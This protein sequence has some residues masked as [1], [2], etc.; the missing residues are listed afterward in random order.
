MKQTKPAQAMELRS[1]SP[2]FAGRPGAHQGRFGLRQRLAITLALFATAGCGPR[3]MD[4]LADVPAGATREQVVSILG[5][6]VPESQL[7]VG[8]RQPPDGCTSQLSYRD[9]YLRSYAQAAAR[10]LPGCSTTW[11]HL[12]FDRDGR[13]APGVRFTMVEC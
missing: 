7:P 12:C 2:V 8:S 13:Y 5:A 1:L 9:E 10:S 4:R 6:P 3:T 11:L